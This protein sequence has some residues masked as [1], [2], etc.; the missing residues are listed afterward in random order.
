MTWFDTCPTSPITFG[1][2]VPVLLLRRRWLFL[3]GW[4]GQVEAVAAETDSPHTFFGIW[5]TFGDLSV[6]QSDSSR[7]ITRELC[8]QE[9]ATTTLAELAGI[10]MKNYDVIWIG[11]GQATGT[12]VPRLT[13]AGKRVAIIEGGMV[14]GSCVN[15]GC[16]PT[17]TLVANGRAAHMANRGAE[18]GIEIPDYSINMTT[19]MDRMN[20]LLYTSP[21]PR[22]ATLSR[23]PSSA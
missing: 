23:M 11:T 14:G 7:P 16:T 4:H 5:E 12:V 21:S 1:A 19:I 18:F 2:G 17:K 13:A 20:C 6:L 8:H 10:S 22:D 3:S 9:A 15:Y